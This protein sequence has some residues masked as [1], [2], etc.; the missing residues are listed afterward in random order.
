MYQG[1]GDESSTTFKLNEHYL[2]RSD[3]QQRGGDMKMKTRIAAIV[4]LVLV[5]AFVF[6][7]LA[8]ADDVI[9]VTATQNV[10]PPNAGVNIDAICPTGTNPNKP[11]YF[12][13]TGGYELLD[14]SNPNNFLIVNSSTFHFHFINNKPHADGW[15]AIGTY[16]GNT[17]PATNTVRV[18]VS[19]KKNED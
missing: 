13:V 18:T 6:P 19:C 7:T 10:T 17:T 12:A 2:A 8:A 3:Q 5:G 9:Y 15:Q 4:L 14:Q 11:A 1:H 16:V